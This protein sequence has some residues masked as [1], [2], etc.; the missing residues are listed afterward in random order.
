MSSFTDPLQLEYLPKKNMWRTTRQFTYYVGEEGSD[1]KI[2]VPKGFTTDLASVPWPA[3]MIIPKS[4]KYNQ[5][6]V[7][8]DYGYFKQERSR[9]EVDAIFLEAM[10][11]L[12][13]PWAKRRIMWLAVRSWGWIPWRNHA[14]KNSESIKKVTIKAKNK[15]A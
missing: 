14:K 13:V 7:L 5:S 12:G 8:H 9:K 15:K 2:T 6:A 4:G 10:G 1:D 11:V 3:E